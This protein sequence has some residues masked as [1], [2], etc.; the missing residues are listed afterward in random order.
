MPIPKGTHLGPYVILEPLGSGGM[1]EV[2]KATDS[3]LGREVAVKVIAGIGAPD[4]TDRQR[5][6]EREARATAALNHPNI[7]T[8]F[9]V[10]THEGLPFLVTELLD[11]QTLR[12]RL[13]Q[14]TKLPSAEA[15]EIA[16]Q[17]TR[18]IAAAHA[19][20]IV[21]RDLKPENLFLTRD[22][23]L[24]I[25]DFGLA[26]LKPEPFAGGSADATTLDDSVPG[27]ISGTLAY[28]APEQT[29]GEPVDARAD[30]FAIG[31]VLY[32]I[33][34]GTNPFRRKSGAETVAAILKEPPPPDTQLTA[35]AL[36]PLILRCLEKDAAD[37][38][39]TTKD[40]GFALESLQTEL[41]QPTATAAERPSQLDDQSSSIAVL[42][43]VDMSPTRDQDYLCEGIA[44]ELLNS[45][46]HIDGLRVAARSSSFQFKG[47][48]IDLQAVGVRLGVA[49]VLEGSV[50]KLGERLRV[51][52]QLVDVTDGYQ[53]WSRR[54]DRQLED[55]FAIQ[56]EI[57]ESVATALRG[58]LSSR[59]KNALR[60]P[61]TAVEAFEYFLRA[62]RLVHR[63]T[64][65]DLELARRM[66]ERAV[67]LD[68]EYAT[69]VAG[70]A[71]VHSWFY[72]W[73][74]GSDADL[75][76]ADQLSRRAMEL[77]PHSAE[78]Q[79]SRAF[80]LSLRHRHDEAD[81]AYEAAIRLNPNSYDA[82]YY[83]GRNSFASGDIE[84]SAELF[85]RAG[86]VREE[87]FQSRVL[88]AQSLAV[89]GR[90]DEAAEANREGLRR[91]ERQ[92]E[93]DPTDPRALSVGA[94]ALADAG[95]ADRALS[96]SRRALELHP[97]DPTVL[98]NAACV[99]AKLG[100]KAEAFQLVEKTFARGWGSRDWIEHDPDFDLLRDDPRFQ[101]LLKNL[102]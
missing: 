7:L 102:R 20:H 80:V 27:K 8:V 85:R 44:E 56:D 19:L 69:A 1:G 17:L 3:R 34:Q 89:L 14:D 82:H 43:F 72:E 88:L 70:L 62:R 57:A 75:D 40:L 50:R 97:E 4:D 100:R 96:W 32:E 63:F 28:M 15:A 92:L 53:R 12:Q 11:G 74:G 24:K 95:E 61:E 99:R 54:Y 55:V 59:E 26:K 86:D 9:D 77:A 87:D 35:P 33:T 81:E 10:G 78:A 73:W 45:L 39:Q 16:V 58:V 37:R 13:T 90:T 52:V 84:R 36:H 49:T 64:R 41:R 94:G 29:R 66:L 101:E 18:G 46:A 48:G 30:I 38:F 21:H 23:T 25:L 91:A 67:E 60:R 42:P 76:R 93:L 83:F 51:N 5:R 71:D 2:Y 31:T 6:F 22:G 47:S 79:T 68:P 98:I 65:A